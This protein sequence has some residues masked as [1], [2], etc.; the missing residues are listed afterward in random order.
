M[1]T[2]PKYRRDWN[3][4]DF[5]CFFEEQENWRRV[6]EHLRELDQEGQLI[7]LALGMRDLG[8]DSI[9]T[10]SIRLRTLAEDVYG[11]EPSRSDCDRITA[12]AYSDCPEWQLDC[13]SRRL[14]PRAA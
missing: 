4:L 7:S 11:L 8:L 6:V 13:K 12:Y 14:G 9:R 5:V 2:I 10:T 1:T 3:L